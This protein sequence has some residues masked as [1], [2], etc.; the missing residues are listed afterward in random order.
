[1]Q[2]T[3][4]EVGNDKIRY[5]TRTAVFLALL[6]VLQ[7][8]TAP[9]GSTIL[10][11]SAVN[12]VLIVSVMTC[13]LGSGMTVALVSPVLAKCLGIGPLWML[14][15]FIAAGNAALVLLWHAVGNRRFVKQRFPYIAALVLAAAAKFLVLYFGVVQVAVPF[16]LHLPEK[17]AAVISEMFSFPQ[18]ITAVIGGTLAAAMLP[19]IKK[20]VGSDSMKGKQGG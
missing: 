7:A 16:L 1:M 3:E 17:Q 18:F 11:G 13:G 12:L 5:I 15:P 14:I 20:A 10:T 4:K 19:V 6:I 8:A 2:K 9:F